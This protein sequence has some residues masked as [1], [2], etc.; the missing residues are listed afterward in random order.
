[1]TQS[2]TSSSTFTISDARYVAA[3]MG[4]DLRGLYARYNEPDAEKIED[5]IE[6]TAQCLK[7]GYL[8]T[9]D[10]GFKRGDEW[11]LRLRYGATIGGQLTDGPTGRLPAASQLSDCHFYSYLRWSDSFYNLSEADKQA[12]RATLPI[13]R[14]SSNAPSLGSGHHGNATE[15]SRHGAGLSRDVFSAY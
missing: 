4:A 6:E 2:L 1:M 13:N 5:Y 10:F 11:I 9:V 14:T 15:Y 8:K 12:F 7:H 3:K